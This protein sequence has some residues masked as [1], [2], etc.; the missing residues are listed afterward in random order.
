MNKFGI[1][2]KLLN[3]MKKKQT[4]HF[5]IM[6][7]FIAHNNSMYHMNKLYTNETVSF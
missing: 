2:S 7:R 4:Q 6:D 5:N 1:L 3:F